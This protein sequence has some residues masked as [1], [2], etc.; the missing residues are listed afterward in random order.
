MQPHQVQSGN[1]DEVDSADT[2]STST[3]TQ[4]P[5]GDDP[6]VSLLSDI[7]PTPTEAND[8][9]LIEKEWVVK[10]KQIVGDMSDDPFR[11]Q[12]EL[13]KLK[14]DYLKKRYGKDVKLTDE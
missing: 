5:I 11:Q 2:T 9:D 6:A 13:S 12:Q 7:A 3:P 4:P 1:D 8:T 14:A 10:A